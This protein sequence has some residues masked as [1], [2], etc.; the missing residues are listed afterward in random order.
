MSTKR[1]LGVIS[2]VGLVEGGIGERRQKSWFLSV[3]SLLDRNTFRCCSV[4]TNFR[5]EEI[6]LHGNYRAKFPFVIA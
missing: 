2:R 4:R 3:I 5:D 6:V 1:K